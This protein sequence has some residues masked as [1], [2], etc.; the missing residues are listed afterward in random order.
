MLGVPRYT[1]TPCRGTWDE[2]VGGSVPGERG[3]HRVVSAP[4]TIDAL[5]ERVEASMQALIGARE[6]PLYHMMGYHIGWEDRQGNPMSNEPPMRHRGVACLTACSAAGGDVE[7]AVPAATAVELIE[8]FCQVHDDVQAGNPQRDGRDSVWWAWGPA[9]AINAGDGL[10]TLARTAIL[11]LRERGVEPAVAFSSLQVL[12]SA[13]LEVFEGRFE[14]L[15]AQERINLSVDAWI[16]MAGRKTGALF[17]CAMKLGALAAS[18]DDSVTDGMATCGRS[19]G[20]AFQARDEMRQV[21]GGPGGQ[22]AA[23]PD[24]LNKKKLIPIVHAFEEANLHTKRRL[25]DIYFKRVLGQE[26]VPAIL[27]ILDELGARDYCESLVQSHRTEAL[28]AAS[29]LPAEGAATVGVFIDT[30]LKD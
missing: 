20:I 19:L 14:D 15:E 23:A 6:M 27:S 28:D 17:G 22:D 3:R 24:V 8:I 2:R 25:G 1:S 26:D 10:Y 9:Q 29:V 21:W 16:G 4:A 11:Q 12:D 5:S 7:A 13:S 18:A 30:V